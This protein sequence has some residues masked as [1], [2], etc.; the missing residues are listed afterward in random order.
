MHETTD[1]HL[2]NEAFICTLIKFKQKKICTC[3]FG[4]KNSVCV[5][6]NKIKIVRSYF[7]D[8]VNSWRPN[9]VVALYLGT[10]SDFTKG[11]KRKPKIITVSTACDLTNGMIGKTNQFKKVKSGHRSKFSN[12]SNWKEEAWKNQ[13]FNGIRTRDLRDTGA[14]LYQQQQHWLYFYNFWKA[15]VA[16]S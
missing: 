4:R 3:I 16:R 13:G 9:E 12:L 2:S 7:C 15:F 14:M 6:K 10:C 11:E 5:H 8:W 1:T